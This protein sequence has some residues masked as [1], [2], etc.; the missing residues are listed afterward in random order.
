[1]TKAE[2]VEFARALFLR[3]E[4]GPHATGA[5]ILAEKPTVDEIM[6]AQAALSEVLGE[7]GTEEADRPPRTPRPHPWG[8]LPLRLPLRLPPRRRLSR[9]EPPARSR[10]HCSFPITLLPTTI[11]PLDTLL[12]TKVLDHYHYNVPS[13][14]P[15]LHY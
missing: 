11:P 10:R 6:I 7:K 9:C 15:T 8:P 14:Q 12:P 1:M 13:P 3:R 4:G 2:A 5:P